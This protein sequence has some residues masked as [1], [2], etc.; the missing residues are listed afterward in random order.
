MRAVIQRVLEARVEVSGQ[1]VSAIEKGLLLYLGVGQ[2]DV[3]A[4]ADYLVDKTLGLRVFED[5][6]GKMNLSLIQVQGSLLVVSQFTLL[7]D[8]RRGKRPSFDRAAG[9]QEAQRL[10]D[11]FVD[12]CKRREI[13]TRT[14]VFREMM[15]VYSVNDGPVTVLLDSRKEF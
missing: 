13:V 11:Y 15:R 1:T 5:S 4:D 2:S 8:C 12:A 10:Y 6:L 14:G 3:E 7:G 9:P